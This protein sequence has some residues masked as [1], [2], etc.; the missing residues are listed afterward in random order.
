MG[1]S[2][3]NRI[4]AAIA[5]C[6]RR[7]GETMTLR[8]VCIACAEAVGA[9]GATLSITGRMDGVPGSLFATD[10]RSEE[11]EELQVT[12]GDGPGIESLRELGPVLVDDLSALDSSIRWPMFA[13]AA[14]RRG[15][16]AVFA[17]PIQAGAARLGVL[18]VYRDRAGPLLGTEFA[19]AL[20]FAGAA[21]AL[22]LD[23]RGGVIP[24]SEIVDDELSV[25]W[26]SEVHQATG[27][28]SVQLGVTVADALA[29]MRAYSFANNRRL[30]VVAADVVAR[31]IRFRPE[32]DADGAADPR[33]NGSERPDV[34]E[35]EEP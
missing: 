27:M 26:R 16:A 28:V 7:D 6:S 4:W 29:R 2:R 24:R 18:A 19:D 12:L 32:N 20:A 9:S 17:F 30:S 34:R 33:D 35:D 23:Q 8:H 3:T 14:V 15:V 5:E 1:D 22:V 21:L 25:A 13:P 11:L 31:T 10:P